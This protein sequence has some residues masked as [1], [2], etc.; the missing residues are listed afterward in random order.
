MNDSHLSSSVSAMKAAVEAVGSTALSREEA[1]LQVAAADLEALLHPSVDDNAARHILAV[2]LAA[3][4]GAA[5]GPIA[6]TS[7]EAEALRARGRQAILVCAQTSP[8]DIYGIQAAAG[9]LTARGGKTSHAALIARGIGKPCVVGAREVRVD[10]DSGVVTIGGEALLRGETITIDGGSGEIFAGAVPMAEPSISGDFATLLGWADGVRRMK[11]RANADTP[12]DARKALAFGA[13]GIGLC[14]SEYMLLERTQIDLIRRMILSE[15]EA[16]RRAVLDRLLPMQR[17]GFAEIFEIMHGRPVTI[18]LLDAPLHEFLPQ[19]ESEI[20]DFSLATGLSPGRVRLLSDSL[21]EANPLLGH[22]GCRLAVTYPEIVE[23]Q[24]RAI[25]EAAIEAGGKTGDPVELEI[26]VPLIGTAGEL[27]FIETR[28]QA[29]AE[30]VRSERGSVPPYLMGTMIE[31]P[32]A[33]LRAAEI[34]ER[35]AFFSFGTNDLTQTVLGIS[36]DD[37]P[38]FLSAYLSAGIFDRDPFVTLDRKAVGE[39]IRLAA[40]RGRA[41]RPSLRLAICGEHGGDPDSIAF[42]EETGLDYVS[43]SPFR[44]PV[45]RLAAAQATLRARKRA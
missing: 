37:A 40:E 27:A 35:A 18:R 6:L 8:S 34:A 38:A 44:V 4:P 24:A 22:R 23:M 10:I 5:S 42:C 25:F 1:L 32:G 39:L 45:A 43:C 31:L 11:V 28:V 12:A 16:E 14:R 41:A 33:A 20:L 26:M 36:R 21:A 19:S 9:I 30:A 29:V 13:E 17:A 7:R 3:S 2:G 15:T